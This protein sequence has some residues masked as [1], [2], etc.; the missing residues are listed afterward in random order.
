MKVIERVQK[1]LVAHQFNNDTKDGLF[2]LLHWY[3]CSVDPSF[4]KDNNPIMKIRFGED[5]EEKTINFTDWIILDNNT[6]TVVE[7]LSD[8]EFTVKYESIPKPVIKDTTSTIE[9]VLVEYINNDA[10]GC[11]SN[12]TN[13]YKQNQHDDSSIVAYL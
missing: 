11:N 10:G 7:V 5:Y 13:K 4:D 3:H 1:E 8:R 12:S 2:M 9:P 6:D